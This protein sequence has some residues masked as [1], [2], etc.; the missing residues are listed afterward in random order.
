MPKLPQIKGDRLVNAL[1]KKG[2]Y[3]DRTR[4]GHVIMRNEN[5]PGTKIVIPMAP[6]ILG[7][8]RK[9]TL[10]VLSTWWEHYEGDITRG[11][12]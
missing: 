7:W 10:F 6:L 8:L 9:L 4:G 5:K 12:R 3:V 1:R 11:L 2:W